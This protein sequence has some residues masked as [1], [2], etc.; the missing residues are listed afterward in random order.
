LKPAKEVSPKKK[1]RV[2]ACPTC[3]GDS[4]FDASNAWRPFCSER[5]KQIDFGAW[6]TEDFR[7]P[8]NPVPDS[9]DKNIN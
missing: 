2:V 8:V 6:A 9:E 5:C 3:A 7:V 4:L 1:L